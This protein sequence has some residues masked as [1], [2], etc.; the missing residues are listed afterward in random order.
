MSAITEHE[1]QIEEVHAMIDEFAHMSNKRDFSSSKEEQENKDKRS[2]ADLRAML[3]A[4]IT[5]KQEF[6]IFG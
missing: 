1:K 6:T 4:V 3:A 5:P 2:L